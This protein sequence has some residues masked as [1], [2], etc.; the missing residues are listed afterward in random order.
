MGDISHIAQLS[1][2][3]IFPTVGAFHLMASHVTNRSY[4][5]NLFIGCSVGTKMTALD[6]PADI[7]EQP[8]LVQ[9][10]CGG[11]KVPLQWGRGKK[12]IC[13]EVYVHCD[14]VQCTI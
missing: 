8:N 11:G 4:N 2:Y 12:N 14:S 5:F 13:A 9:T 10:G 1:C 7:R 6:T 3:M